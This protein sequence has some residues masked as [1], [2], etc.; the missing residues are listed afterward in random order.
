MIISFDHYRLLPVASRA[1]HLLVGVRLIGFLLADYNGTAPG[2]TVV[3]SISQAQIS[4]MGCAPGVKGL[5]LR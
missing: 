3:P 2:V 4:G 1:G 5:G